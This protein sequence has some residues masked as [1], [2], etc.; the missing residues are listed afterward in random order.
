MRQTASAKRK[1]SRVIWTAPRLQWY[2]YGIKTL[3]GAAVVHM[4][5]STSD[6]SFNID[7]EVGTHEAG[8]KKS[9][10]SNLEQLNLSHEAHTGSILRKKVM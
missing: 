5:F 4:Q 8:N 6:F 7:L 9:L 2:S 1:W 3:P 10:S